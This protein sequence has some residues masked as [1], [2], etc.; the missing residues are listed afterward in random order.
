VELNEG[1]GVGVFE[2]GMSREGSPACPEGAGGVGEE[3]REARVSGGESRLP[4]AA[5]KDSGSLAGRGR[6]ACSRAASEE[7]SAAAEDWSA[8]WL[9]GT[10]AFSSKVSGGGEDEHPW[11]R[12]QELDTSIEVVT[13]SVKAF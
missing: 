6:A 8:L 4:K 1:L 9:M 3:K 12:T 13:A 2:G 7:C 11:Y 5:R 10:S